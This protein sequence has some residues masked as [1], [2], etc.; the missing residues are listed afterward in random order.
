MS[1]GYI[2]VKTKAD[3]DMSLKASKSKIFPVLNSLSTKP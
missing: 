3:V 2:P 1:Y